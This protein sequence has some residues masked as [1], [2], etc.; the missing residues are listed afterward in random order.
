MDP[1]EHPNNSSSSTV[2]PGSGYAPSIPPNLKTNKDS[3]IKELLMRA[4]A[5]M[6]TD[7]IEK[8]AHLSYF[9]GEVYESKRNYS[10]ALKFYK[11]FLGFAK[12]M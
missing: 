7:D 6:N 2:A 11:R 3:N 4:K 10:A 1:P 5:G 9:L 8:E 12:A